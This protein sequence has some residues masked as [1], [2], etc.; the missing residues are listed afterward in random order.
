MSERGRMIPMDAVCEIL[1]CERATVYELIR[2]GEV[3][4]YTDGTR[5][6]VDALSLVRYVERHTGTPQRAMRLV[7]ELPPEGEEEPF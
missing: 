4:A 1:E 2:L 7:L 3:D 6:L 5:L